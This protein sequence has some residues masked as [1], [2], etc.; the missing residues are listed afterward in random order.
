[1]NKYLEKIAALNPVQKTFALDI[2]KKLTGNKDKIDS[3][4]GKARAATSNRLK[5]VLSTEEATGVKQ[6]F[7]NAGNKL[8]GAGKE[9]PDRFTRA[10]AA[11][12]RLARM[13]TKITA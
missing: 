1:M 3:L 2:A 4:Y 11:G 6:A 7:G 9:T 5:G 10:G 12:L 13:K 8:V